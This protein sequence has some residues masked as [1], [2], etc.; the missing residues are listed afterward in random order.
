MAEAESFFLNHGD[1]QRVVRNK[2]SRGIRLTSFWSTYRVSVMVAIVNGMR[3]QRQSVV[4]ILLDAIAV[5]EGVGG[6]SE[7]GS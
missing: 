2:G 6:S 1:Y 4:V 3:S 7:S 5:L